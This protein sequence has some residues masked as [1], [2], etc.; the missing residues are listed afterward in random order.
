MLVLPLLTFVETAHLCTVLCL[1]HILELTP[2]H[3]RLI[4]EVHKY[5]FKIIN[6][7]TQIYFV[8]NFYPKIG[9]KKSQPTIASKEKEAPSPTCWGGSIGVENNAGLFWSAGALV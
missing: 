1:F 5:L 6:Y 4:L 7:Q 2:D 9:E 8:G 3:N